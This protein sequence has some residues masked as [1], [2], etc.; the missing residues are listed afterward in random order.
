M[1]L[2]TRVRTYW[3]FI[4]VAAEKHSLDPYLV[5]AIMDRESLCGLALRPEGPGGTGD[6][7]HGRGLMQIDDRAFPEFCT[8]LMP[9]GTPLWADPLANIEQACAILAKS[10]PRFVFAKAPSVAMVAAYNCG[11]GRVI[12]ALLHL[13]QP[14]TAEAELAELDQLCTHGDYC[15]DVIRRI[16]QFKAPPISAVPPPG[17]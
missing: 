9:D 15:S 10:R 8:T 17:V 6:G 7:T 5:A 1:S 11:A 2:P 4:Q 12:H 16:G 14:T 3:T 13:T